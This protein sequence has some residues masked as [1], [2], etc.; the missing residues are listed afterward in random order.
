MTREKILE[1]IIEGYRNT[2]YQRYQYQNI[3]DN[4][5]IPETINEETVNLLRNYWLNYIYPDFIKR[6]ELNEA[7]QRLD[8]Y[9]KNPKKLLRILLDATKLIFNYGRHLPKI[10]TTGLKAMKTFRA[11]ERFENC[12]VD[13]AIKNKIEAPYDESKI[14]AL[15]KLLP[16]KEIEKFI[17]ISQSL[18][19]IL[20]DRIQI[21]KIKGIIQYLI[22]AMRS[23]EESYSLSQIR[24][25]EIGLEMLI[26]GDKLF[27]QL[28]KED[29]KNLVYLI[30]EIERD[31]LDNNIKIPK[32]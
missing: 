20:H 23:R 10:L 2:I 30:T 7:F 31:M 11:A 6:A 29:Q 25:L 1:E 5:E 28:A 21:E 13:E 3:K 12:F 4:Y 16:R 15:I 18:F 8:N 27:T 26:E 19:E 9:I 24:G 32:R 22:L 14:N 17:D